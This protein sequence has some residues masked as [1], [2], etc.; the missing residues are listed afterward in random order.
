ML[1]GADDGV[2]PP[3]DAGEVAPHFTALRR[4]TVLKG[5]G[6][7]IPQEAPAAFADAVLEL[8]SSGYAASEQTPPA[9][10][11]ITTAK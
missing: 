7:D 8:G 4:R 5:V 6:H 9:S 1:E 2:D 10:S 11:P 3:T